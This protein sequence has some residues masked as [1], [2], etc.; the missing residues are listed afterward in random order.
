MCSEKQ[1]KA[2]GT[3][4]DI[5]RITREHSGAWGGAY[6]QRIWPHEKTERK[7]EEHSIKGNALMRKCKWAPKMCT[8]IGKDFTNRNE[9]TLMGILAEEMMSRPEAK[10]P[11][12]QRDGISRDPS[13]TKCFNSVV[14]G[15]SCETTWDSRSTGLERMAG[16]WQPIC[17][18]GQKGDTTHCA[19]E[20]G[21]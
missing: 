5:I 19:G 14:L 2:K 15:V 3:G 9:G 16:T 20:S 13:T 12:Q 18:F 1:F 7:T 4:T 10:H 17:S 8:A 11:F 21:N 6:W